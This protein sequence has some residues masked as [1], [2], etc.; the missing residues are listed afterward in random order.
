MVLIPLHTQII[1]IF[2]LCLY[3]TLNNI[4]QI[5]NSKWEIQLSPLVRKVS[6]KSQ[7]FHEMKEKIQKAN[8][9]FG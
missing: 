2:L 7:G 5:P 1:E 8:H 4:S 9:L 6:K 3:Y